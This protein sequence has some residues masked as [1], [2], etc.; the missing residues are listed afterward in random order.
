MVL[1]KEIKNS[2]IFDFLFY[3]STKYTLAKQIN[4]HHENNH[5]GTKIINTKSPFHNQ[6]LDI[7][8]TD[9]FIE[10]IGASLPN[11][12]NSDEIRHVE[13]T[14]FNRMVLTPVFRLENQV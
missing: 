12:E 13:F 3:R 6:T 4:Y 2:P 10:K 8:I 7:L 11:T 9:G 5:P 14:S 1:F